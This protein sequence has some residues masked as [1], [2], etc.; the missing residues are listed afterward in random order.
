MKEQYGVMCAVAGEDIVPVP[1]EEVAGKLKRVPP[2]CALI[3][4]ARDIGMTFGD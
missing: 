1:L 4:R 2:G 3:Q